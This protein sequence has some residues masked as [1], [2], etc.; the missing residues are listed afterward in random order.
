MMEV[1]PLEPRDRTAIA[2]FVERIPE[3]DRTFFKENVAE[4]ETVDRWM[5]PDAS[6]SVALDGSSVVGYVAV[7]PLQGWSS[8]VGEVRVIV[9]PDHRGK[10]IGRALARHAVREAL[11]LGLSKMVVEVI[12]D[13]ES[14]IALFRSHGF[15]PEA[16]LVD[17]V[18]DRSGELRD[19][20]ILV[21][22][23][24][25]SLASLS[26]TGVADAD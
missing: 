17:H 23:V 2:R 15:D 5:R 19:P 16:L 18:R 9:D 14:T 8:H 22:S 7:V 12:A 13:Q 10:G 3:G 26:A 24:D 25:E 11:R 4:P 20:M 1:R 21:H 6:R